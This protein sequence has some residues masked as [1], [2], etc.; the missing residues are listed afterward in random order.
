MDD[1]VCTDRIQST[2]AGNY[3]VTRMYKAFGIRKFPSYNKVLSIN[4]DSYDSFISCREK[5]RSDSTF[6]SKCAKPGSVPIFYFCLLY[7]S[8]CV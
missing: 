3:M 2:V 7:T 1:L 8:R 5:E 6:P 4:F